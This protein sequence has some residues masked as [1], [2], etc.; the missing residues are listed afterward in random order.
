MLQHIP[1]NHPRI[2]R[3]LLRL[4]PFQ[5]REQDRRVLVQVLH[6][7]PSRPDLPPEEVVEDLHDVL[8][9]FE[10]EAGEVGD[11][12]E[13]EVGGVGF[14]GELGDEFG[15]RVWWRVRFLGS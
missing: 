14:L 5:R 9:G 12:V 4:V 8:A 2:Q 3:H 1:Q 11:E 10:F 13:E 6:R 15:E 7:R